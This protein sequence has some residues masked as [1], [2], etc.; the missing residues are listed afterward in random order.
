MMASKMIYKITVK[1]FLKYNKSLKKGHKAILLSTGFLE[2][3]KVRTLPGGGKLLYLGLILRCGDLT[4]TSIEAT[5]EQLVTFAGGKG[6]VVSRLLAQLEEL[7]LVTVEKNEILLN[8][9]EKKRKEKKGITEVHTKID[10]PKKSPEKPIEKAS[11]QLVDDKSSTSKKCQFL[12]R[13]Y[14]HYFKLKHGTTPHITG[15]DSG[16]AKRIANDLS[17]DKIDMYLNA[18][19]SLPEGKLFKAKHPLSMFEFHKNEIVH[20]ANSGKFT[21]NTQ[22][23]HLD[24]SANSLSMLQQVREGKL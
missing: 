2:D 14:C 24:Q 12:I 13:T 7:Q 1:N 5:P 6:Q 9:I 21:T 10:F 3:P 15:K 18:F 23:N 4:S 20:F 17:E 16:I 19:F 8:R 11:L 22:A